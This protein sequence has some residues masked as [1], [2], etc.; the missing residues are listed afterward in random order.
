M[1][2]PGH[3]GS[4]GERKLVER[5]VLEW[6]QNAIKPTR[7]CSPV[8]CGN[9]NYFLARKK[10]KKRVPL[11]IDSFLSFSTLDHAL[12]GSDNELIYSSSVK[13]LVQSA[14][15]GYNGEESFGGKRSD[16]DD[17]YE[18]AD[19]SSNFCSY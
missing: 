11:L 16:C 2:L 9:N 18:C 4:V 6:H 19:T 15:E 17:G 10:K 13:H 14:M 3:L 12:T 1:A 5:N 7:G 8:A